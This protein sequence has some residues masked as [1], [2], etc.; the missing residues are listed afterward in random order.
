MLN[1]KI[2]DEQ[3]A[4]DAKEA[5]SSETI[6]HKIIANVNQ[7]SS[8]WQQ[9]GFIGHVVAINEDETFT[10]Y[11]DVP[12]HYLHDNFTDFASKYFVITLEYGDEIFK[13]ATNVFAVERVH[14]DDSDN[15]HLSAFLHPVVREYDATK[16]VSTHHIIEDFESKWDEE[17]VHTAPLIKYLKHQ[18]AN[19]PEVVEK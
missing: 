5:I 2:K 11:Y 18:L 8:I 1:K 15:A 16:L 13:K 9:F 6:G 7:A 19:H 12:V 3:W 4:S 10:Y 17:E 14:K